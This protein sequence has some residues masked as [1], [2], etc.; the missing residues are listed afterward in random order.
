[1]K[2]FLT[3]PLMGL[4]ATASG[5]ALFLDGVTH[6]HDSEA[7]TGVVLA[8]VGAVVA[9]VSLVW[10]RRAIVAVITV[11]ALVPVA[12]VGWMVWMLAHDPS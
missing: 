5:G 3:A 1:V 8:V 12:F 10:A 2:R 7:W 4:A 6:V 9:L 11:F